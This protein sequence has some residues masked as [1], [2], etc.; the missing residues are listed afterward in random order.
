MASYES[1]ISVLPALST[2]AGNDYISI[3]NLTLEFGT[4]IYFYWVTVPI[5]DD[6]IIETLQE[7]FSAILILDSPSLPR[8]NISPSQAEVT[9]GDGN[10]VYMFILLPGGSTVLHVCLIVWLTHLFL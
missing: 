8:I 5:L 7:S 1:H 10:A 9:I 2:I 3:S 6:N 4:T